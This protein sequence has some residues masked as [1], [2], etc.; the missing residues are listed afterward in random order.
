MQS[1]PHAWL[2]SYVP[3]LVLLCVCSPSQHKRSTSSHEGR[4]PQALKPR[5]NDSPAL[6]SDFIGASSTTSDTANRTQAATDETQRQKHPGAQA[7]RDIH[8][9]ALHGSK[10]E[11]VQH[12]NTLGDVQ[13]SSNTKAEDDVQPRSTHRD[14]PCSGNFRDGGEQSSGTLRDE[15]RSS[16]FRAEGAQPSST[17]RNAQHIGTSGNAQDGQDPPSDPVLLDPCSRLNRVVSKVLANASMQQQVQHGSCTSSSRQN[18]EPPPP[19][20]SD[21]LP[22]QTECHTVTLASLEQASR[23][24][25]Q[26]TPLA[27]LVLGHQ[28]GAL[29]GWQLRG[30]GRFACASSTTT[31]VRDTAMARDKAGVQGSNGAHL[32]EGTSRGF[33]TGSE[34]IDLP[35]C[36]GALRVK[37]CC[38]E[39][40]ELC[41]SATH[42][43]LSGAPC[44]GPKQEPLGHLQNFQPTPD[45][46]DKILEGQAWEAS[47]R[48]WL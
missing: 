18:A 34:A 15:P 32:D 31:E 9:R 36:P 24:Q 3:L 21:P 8:T 47:L 2:C 35:A 27:L 30:S 28:P 42:E 39:V 40:Q 7:A 6:F 41:K 17:L 46:D 22:S 43:S 5:D 13:I 20:H 11:G 23:S 16:N 12:S 37:V 44:K 45:R 1:L 19:P 25:A 33:S 48:G 14:D 29:E 38:V 4:T 26:D 10:A